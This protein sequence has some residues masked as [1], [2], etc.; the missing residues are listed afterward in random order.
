MSYDKEP[1][2]INYKDMKVPESYDGPK[3]NKISDL[4]AEWY[5]NI[6]YFCNIF[7]GQQN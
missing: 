6:Y 3:L 4:T 5:F 7:T 1:E 2:P